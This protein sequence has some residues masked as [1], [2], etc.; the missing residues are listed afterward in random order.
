MIIDKYKPLTKEE[1][2]KYVEEYR[3]NRSEKAAAA[4]LFGV[5]RVF[6]S[7]IYNN[8]SK[9]LAQIPD[10]TFDDL[11]NEMV[12]RFYTKLPEFDPSQAKLNTWITWNIKP[13]V[14]NTVKTMRRKFDT[15]HRPKSLDEPVTKDGDSLGKFLPDGSID[16]EDNYEKGSQK[17]KLERAIKK[18]KKEDQEII[19]N[20]FGYVEPKKEW[21]S[22]TGK[23]NAA[24][25]A[26]GM[27]ISADR[28]RARV[29][30]ILTQLKSDLS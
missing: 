24:S 8:E 17:N 6:A 22:K 21:Q 19:M 30:R 26:R 29:E 12:L 11:F 16:V 3:K 20:L 1:E 25:I 7:A 14:L 23:I 10:V 13:L 4:L 28:V 18:L 9:F 27:G 2:Y 5:V 15:K